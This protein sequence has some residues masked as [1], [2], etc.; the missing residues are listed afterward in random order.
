M[1]IAHV[2]TK[3][4]VGGAQ[5]H[6][7]ELTRAQIE[8]GDDVTVIAGLDGPAMD[9]ARANRVDVRIVPTLGGA[10][11]R[12]WQGAA[13]RDVRAALASV[14]P[15]IVH[16]HSSN[17][18]LLARVASWRDEYPCVYTAHGWPFQRGA[19]LAQ[20]VLSF[21]GEFVGGHL[22]D[23]VICLTEEEARRAR[24]VRVAPKRKL[25]IVPNG[26]ADVAP[27]LRR[28]SGTTADAPAI[29]MV[30]RFASPK[31]QHEVIEAM[32]PL[33]DRPWSLTFVGDGPGF[34]ACTALGHR[35]LGDRVTFLG[36]RD[37]VPAILA[38]H[39]I[40]LLWSRYEG[41]PISL[42]EGMR[43][44]LC[45]VGS[46]LPGIRALLGEPRAGIVAVDAAG[47]SAAVGALIADPSRIRELG[48]L[49]R[50]RF[51][52]RYSAHAMETAT[53]AV[54]EAARAGHAG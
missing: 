1:R 16:G 48:G 28:G 7:V 46:D 15:D 39:D 53:R 17:G 25:W 11:S 4:D 43:A 9:R 54:Y 35:L 42:L 20:R 19:P 27:E 14:R 21:G 31:L 22:G 38:A 44:G 2:I 8:A 13:L 18:G 5:T 12:W 41:M 6:V 24:R 30:A 34:D 33:L 23:A 51:E 10:R 32:K 52:Q 47:L 36:H 50:R 3:G 26:L 29:V 45:C 49:A 37:D 40:C